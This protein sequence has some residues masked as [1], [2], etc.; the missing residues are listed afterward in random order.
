MTL[1]EVGHGLALTV[2]NSNAQAGF[3]M[4]LTALMATRRPPG[5]LG[6]SLEGVSASQPA[7]APGDLNV[8]SVKR[9]CF[10]IRAFL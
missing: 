10:T 7:E 8:L 3:T 6:A 5:L 4:T 2:E 1:P 9:R